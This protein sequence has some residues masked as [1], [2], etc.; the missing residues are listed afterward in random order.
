MFC[1]QAGVSKPVRQLVS[2]L[3]ECGWLYNR[4]RTYV[5]SRSADKAF[6][7]IGQ[8]FCAALHQEL[9]EYYRLIAVLEAQ[10]SWLVLIAVPTDRDKQYK[11]IKKC[12][13]NKQLFF[14][15]LFYDKLNMGIVF[16]K[17]APSFFRT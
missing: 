3:G 13:E 17:P 4:I 15:L 1:L 14:F 10:V 7:L 6:G 2:K 12:K 16:S 8:S 11:S 5:Q 9:T